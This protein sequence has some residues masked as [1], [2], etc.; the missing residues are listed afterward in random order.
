VGSI[1]IAADADAIYWM[2]VFSSSDSPSYK[3]WR[4]PRWGG[5]VV[6]VGSG[7][8]PPGILGFAL[9]PSLV[10]VKTDGTLWKIPRD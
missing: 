9:G 7:T 4:A 6:S 3:L 1:S 2:T 10:V 8:S 5:A